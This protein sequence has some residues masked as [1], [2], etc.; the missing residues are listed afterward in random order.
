MW[1]KRK[2][3]EGCA[4]I[5]F[6]LHNCGK[7]WICKNMIQILCFQSPGTE[8]MLRAITGKKL[9]FSLRVEFLSVAQTF[10]LHILTPEHLKKKKNGI[11]ELQHL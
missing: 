5:D 2:C 9:C 6:I 10:Q 3:V 11:V 4:E 1:T 7:V 8:N